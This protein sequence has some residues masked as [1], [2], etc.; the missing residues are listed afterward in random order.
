L[1]TAGRWYVI[2]MSVR[3]TVWEIEAFG[4]ACGRVSAGWAPAAPPKRRRRAKL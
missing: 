4:L 3:P 2:A 1:L